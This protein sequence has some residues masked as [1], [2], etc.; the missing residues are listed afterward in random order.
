MGNKNPIIRE[1][2]AKTRWYQSCKR[3][4][5]TAL[6]GRTEASVVDIHGNS[7][8]MRQ[9]IPRWDGGDGALQQEQA[10]PIYFLG[11]AAF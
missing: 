4:D 5:H 7:V 3:N 8:V 10:D 9:L 2:Q 1:I 6:Q 11:F